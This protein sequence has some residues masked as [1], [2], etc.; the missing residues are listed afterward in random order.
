MSILFLRCTARQRR[1]RT[2]V[3]ASL[4][5]SPAATA[6]RCSGF[7]RAEE[8]A[9]RALRAPLRQLRRARARSALRAPT[10]TLA[11]LSALEAR[12]RGSAHAF[13]EVVFA[14]HRRRNGTRLRGRRWPAGAISVAARSADSGLARKARFVTD[15]P[16]LLER[17]AQRVASSA[18][19]PRIEHRSAVEA[20]RRPPQCEPPPATA[21]REAREKQ[22]RS[23]DK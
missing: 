12:C 1:A 2:P 5:R 10:L 18:A 3:N 19:Q 20:K 13:A 23:K 4:K 14:H 16:R 17:S 11:L 7:G 21:C 15:S 8:L 6:L 22:S 9:A